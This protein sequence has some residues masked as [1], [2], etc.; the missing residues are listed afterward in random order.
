MRRLD[1]PAHPR[2][3]RHHGEGVQGE[4]VVVDARSELVELVL[5][6][7]L[8]RLCATL[9]HGVSGGAWCIVVVG[10]WRHR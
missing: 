2:L 10:D 5:L 4:G 1:P 8:A 7:S 6:V 9:V 3:A